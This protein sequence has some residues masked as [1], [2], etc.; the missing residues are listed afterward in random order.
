[1]KMTCQRNVLFNHHVWF[2][3]VATVSVR[4]WQMP[5]VATY[6]LVAAQKAARSSQPEFCRPDLGSLSSMA[7]SGKKQISNLKIN[8][9]RKRADFLAARNGVR[10]SG[11]AVRIEAFNTKNFDRA[12]RIGLTVTKKNGNAVMRNRIKRRLRA[13][14]IC[15]GT[16]EMRD[17]HDYVFI[18]RPIAL[19]APFDT[20]RHDVRTLIEKSHKRLDEKTTRSSQE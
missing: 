7:K 10:A 1:M 3:H 11:S 18:S 2:A 5:Q 9:I 20:L 4:V 16:D 12:P 8:P 13:A 15:N 6:W 17:A 19:H 14:I